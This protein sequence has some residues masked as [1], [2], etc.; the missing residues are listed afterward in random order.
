[1][2]VSAK[3]VRS[4]I[5]GATIAVR[6]ALNSGAATQP[7]TPSLSRT[8]RQFSNSAKTSTGSPARLYT[9]AI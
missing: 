7:V 4:L 6:R 9:Q 5:Q 3:T 2:D 1:M 8:C